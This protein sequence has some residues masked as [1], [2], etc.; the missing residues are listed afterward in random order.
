[1]A[2]QTAADR[3]QRTAGRLREQLRG[4]QCLRAVE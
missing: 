2:S 4:A 1:V 3:K